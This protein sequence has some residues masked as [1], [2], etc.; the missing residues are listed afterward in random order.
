MPG[1]APG[2]RFSELSL[3]PQ[4]WESASSDVFAGFHPA[5]HLP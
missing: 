3:S 4:N 5:R 2:M 1:L